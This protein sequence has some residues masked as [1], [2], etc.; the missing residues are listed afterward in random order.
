M[1]RLTIY[2]STIFILAISPA[3]ATSNS[4]TNKYDEQPTIT[5]EKYEQIESEINQILTNIEKQIN[6]QCTTEPTIEKCKNKDEI[7]KKIKKAADET[8]SELNALGN[9]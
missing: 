6:S 8:L 9:N 3:L 2:F 4:N 1:K 5:K 7:I